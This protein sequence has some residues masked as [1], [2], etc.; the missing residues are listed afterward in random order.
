M[1]IAA[2]VLSL[3][4][5]ILWQT[6]AIPV[7]PLYARVGPTVI[8]L[9]T[10]VGLGGCGLALL[11]LALRGGWQ[12]AEEKETA[13]DKRALLLLGAGFLANMALIGTAGFTIAS[14]ILFALTARA[15]GSFNLAR[16]AATGFALAIIAYLGFARALGINIGAGP[17]ERLIERA[18]SV[19]F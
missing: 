19:I 5:L 13:P 4:A 11:V 18:L 14:T 7:S 12:D 17:P 3:A 15:F 10:A 2:G 8:P 1:L 9:L 16:D 6:L